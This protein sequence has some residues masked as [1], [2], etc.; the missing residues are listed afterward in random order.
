VRTASVLSVVRA[1]QP[2]TKSVIGL[3][4]STCFVARRLIMIWSPLGKKSRAKPQSLDFVFLQWL[5]EPAKLVRNLFQHGVSD[6]EEESHSTRVRHCD[7]R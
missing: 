5:A 3:R 7:S 6:E 4:S 1:P 2:Q